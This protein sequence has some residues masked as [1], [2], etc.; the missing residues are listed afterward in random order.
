MK[1]RWI[2]LFALSV[3][4]VAGMGI[5]PIEIVHHAIAQTEM[6][7]YAKWGR[8]ALQ[9]TKEKY[10]NA[11]IVDYLHIGRD[12]QANVTTEKFKLWLRTNQKEFG[13]F[14]NIQFN[15]ATERV[16]G[17]TFQETPR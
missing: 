4:S 2:T 15:T 16:I 9:K 6:P 1:N 3:W 13:V 14:V 11:Q 17:I 10:P 7:P 5:Q 12:Q 8:L